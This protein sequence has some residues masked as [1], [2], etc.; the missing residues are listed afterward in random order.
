MVYLPRILLTDQTTCHNSNVYQ[1]PFTSPLLDWVKP[2]TSGAWIKDIISNCITLLLWHIWCLTPIIIF[3]SSMKC[4]LGFEYAAAL[5][6]L[7]Y[8]IVPLVCHAFYNAWWFIHD[9]NS[10]LQEAQEAVL[11]YGFINGQ[12]HTNF[13]AW[14][15]IPYFLVAQCGFKYVSNRLRHLK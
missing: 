12:P 4:T 7:T 9:K 15:S 11:L 3:A 13:I 6:Y 2:C 5:L 1:K 8:G 14:L 10:Y